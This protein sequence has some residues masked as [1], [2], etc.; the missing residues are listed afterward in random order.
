MR[1]ANRAFAWTDR[2]DRELEACVNGTMLSATIARRLGTD[3]ETVDRRIAERGL[4]RPR[5]TVERR[6]R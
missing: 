1:S 4:E 3:A 5:P 6:A 2:T